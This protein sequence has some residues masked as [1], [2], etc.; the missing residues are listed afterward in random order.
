MIKN[1]P[2]VLQT[3][4]SQRTHWKALLSCP[5]V[6]YKDPRATGKPE[7]NEESALYSSLGQQPLNYLKAN[8]IFFHMILES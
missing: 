6:L 3:V 4:T 1:N 7:N 5:L 8:L 2:D